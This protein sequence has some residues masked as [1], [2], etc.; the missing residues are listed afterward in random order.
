M[1]HYHDYECRSHLRSDIVRWNLISLVRTLLSD[2]ILMPAP[3]QTTYLKLLV[4]LFCDDQPRNIL[5]QQ[6][7]FESCSLR[8]SIPQSD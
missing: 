4:Y 8:R 7:L 6:S 3:V 2:Y 1:S 5:M